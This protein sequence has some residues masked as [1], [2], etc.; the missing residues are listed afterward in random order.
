MKQIFDKHK[1]IW[2]AW[3]NVGEWMTRDDFLQFQDIAYLDQKQKRG[4][5]CLHTNPMLS[6]QSWVCV[7]LDDVFNFQDAGE[8]NGIHVPFTIGIQTPM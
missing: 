3:A 6:I 2:W 5:W 8:V 7:H 4:I 1:E